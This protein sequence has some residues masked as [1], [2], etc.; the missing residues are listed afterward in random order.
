MDQHLFD[1]CAR[2]LRGNDEDDVIN[3][4]LVLKSARRAA[5]IT[6]HLHSMAHDRPAYA[7]VFDAMQKSV[8]ALKTKN[9]TIDAFRRLAT[10]RV[11][12]SASTVKLQAFCDQNGVM[13]FCNNPFGSVLV[14]RRDALNSDDVAQY[15]L[16]DEH[17]NESFR[18]L[19]RLLE[20]PQ[21]SDDEH[22][23]Y[24]RGEWK[25]RPGS[26]VR[27]DVSEGDAIVVAAY[28]HSVKKTTGLMSVAAIDDAT[29]GLRLKSGRTVLRCVRELSASP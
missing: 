29:R 15:M 12:S 10:A 5:L 13:V 8:D 11:F 3:L 22:K 23:A 16:F 2:L 17:R 9:E 6:L 28:M 7:R 24:N 27:L 18:A 19:A 20:Y 4:Y 1:K 14:I 21:L 26:T 25:T